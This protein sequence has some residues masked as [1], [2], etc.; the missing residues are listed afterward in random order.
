MLLK[1]L[2]ISLFSLIITSCQTM[3]TS[4]FEVMIVLPASRDCYGVKVMSKAE[5]RIPRL[6]C[7]QLQRRSLFITSENYK[8]LKTDVQNNCQFQ[9]C[10]QIT[11]AADG[12][13]LAID[14]ALQK[15]PGGIP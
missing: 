5:R 2:G 15:I 12:L 13:F 4:D 9:Q 3:Q 1:L 14:E 7:E 11:G 6:E 8:L 10:K